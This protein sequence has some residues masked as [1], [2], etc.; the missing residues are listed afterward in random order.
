MDFNLYRYKYKSQRR[1]VMSLRGAVATSQPL[2][3]EAGLTMLQQGGNAFDAVLAAAAVLTV[4]EPTSNGLGGDCFALFKANGKPI[5]GLNSSGYLPK[6]FKISKRDDLISDKEMHSMRLDPHSWQAVTVP[7]Q[8]A[9]WQYLRNN[10]GNLGWDII[11]QPAWHYAREGFP[12]SPEVSYNWMAAIEKYNRVLSNEFKNNFMETFSIHGRAPR[13]GEIWK[14]EYQ[15][16]TLQRLK[17]A[18]VKDFYQGQIAEK[19]IDYSEE[20]GGYFQAS[21]L[22]DFQPQEVSPLKI[23]YRGHEIYELPPNGQG[24]IA[25]QALKMLETYKFVDFFSPEELHYKIEA[26]KLAFA[27][28]TKY[29]GDPHNS[30]INP[31]K[32][33]DSKY[34]GVRQRQIG[35]K[36]GL[37]KPGEID[38]SGTVYLAAADNQG[39]LVS[40]IQSNYNGFGS[41]IVI[42]KTG[43]SL[44]NRGY[45][46]ILDKNSINY[47]KPGKKPYHTIIPGFYNKPGEY[48]GPFGVMGGFMQPQAHLQVIQN[49]VDYDCNPQE[50]LDAPRWRWKDGKAL[51]LEKEFPDY[52]ARELMNRGHEIDFDPMAF[53]GLGQIIFKDLKRGALI[54]ATEPRADGQTAVF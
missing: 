13:A 29:I 31:M 45:N 27:D 47:P 52:L 50:A 19:F 51:S 32:L 35:S 14:S 6:N 5:N 44:H 7:G 49:I 4:V 48:M 42:P 24:L 12:V 21:D 26:I 20:T 40:F 54:T 53:F 25:L 33:L 46:F 16:A 23:D 8:L 34:L 43:I 30:T 9:G 1:A 11:L 38:R 37:Y 39:N 3:S 41:G 22:T 18:G 2:A 17:D 28:G 10:Y 36:A 15:A